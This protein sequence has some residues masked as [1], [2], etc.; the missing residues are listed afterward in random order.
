MEFGRHRFLIQPYLDE[1]PHLCC[2]KASQIGF[3]TMAILK[4][5]RMASRYG[6]NIIH[7]LPTDGDVEKF[8]STKVDPIIER[9]PA[10]A[11]Y[12]GTTDNVH[13][14]A[15]KDAF[16]FYLGT[17]GQSAG[18][19][20]S[21]DLNIH[22]EL[23]RS[24]RKT[25]ETFASRIKHSSYRG[26]WIFSNPSR[27]RVGVDVYWSMSD[28]KEWHVTCHECQD[29]QVL[30]YFVNVDEDERRFKCRSCGA[31]I[32]DDDR[33]AGRWIAKYPDR[34]WSGYHIP[35]LIAPWISAGDLIDDHRTKTQEFFYNFDL[36]L[37][38]IGDTTGVTASVI[39]QCC[40]DEDPA[41]PKEW[42]TKFRML[43][44]DI[45]SDLHCIQGNEWGVTRIFNLR[46]WDALET[47][48]TTQGIHLCIVDNAPNVQQA[49]KFV[50][51]HPGRAYRC[52]YDYNDKRDALVDFIDTGDNKGIVYV[53][54]TRAIDQLIETY[55][56]QEV[57][58]YLKPNDPQLVG[59]GKQGVT[60]NCLCD[61]W[62]T[63]YT[64]GD[65]GQDI[66][67]V[68]HDKAGNVIRTWE[69]TGPDHFVHANV[70]FETSRQKKLPAASVE[71]AEQ[72]RRKRARQ[73]ATRPVVSS[74]T[75][76]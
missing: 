30:D 13:L 2:M 45:G 53:H 5:I 43:G 56:S 25:V 73:Q 63:L 31:T 16:V 61:H 23:D 50:K 10:I 70:Y 42:P 60:E 1:S 39:L 44:V 12:I 71:P 62:E 69:H 17:K 6:R 59:Q 76:Y 19:M 11:Q 66:N 26:E 24:D 52:V 8:V 57:K 54:R 32:T 4:G 21:A 27:P 34:E 22:D 46:D 15:V 14:K 67:I 3:S 75:G 68:K 33:I 9:N 72:Q 74:R 51:R 58:V 37:P 48:F 35:Q 40:T 28:Q 36:A 55:Q 7:T 47:Y 64:A 20:V 38:V 29:E 65:D 49:E 18:I 41:G